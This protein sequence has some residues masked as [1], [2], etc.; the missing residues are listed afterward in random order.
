MLTFIVSFGM[1]KFQKNLEIDIFKLFP[2]RIDKYQ[3][4]FCIFFK[5]RIK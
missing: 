1:I 4:K 3:S 5:T 2:N